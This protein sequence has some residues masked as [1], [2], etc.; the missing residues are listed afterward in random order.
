M[1][2]LEIVCHSSKW[3]VESPWWSSSDNQRVAEGS[4]AIQSI[5]E[6]LVW[7]VAKN[8]FNL[9]LNKVKHKPFPLWYWHQKFCFKAEICI[10][11]WWHGNLA[12]NFALVYRSQQNK[13][14]QGYCVNFVSVNCW[15]SQHHRK[16][17]QLSQR[18][19]VTA[20]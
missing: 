19:F 9:F 5:R 20:K 6:L 2:A 13:D 4:F 11:V 8:I 15:P 10:D 14:S 7:E 17:L 12:L 3:T 16:I 18:H 1:K